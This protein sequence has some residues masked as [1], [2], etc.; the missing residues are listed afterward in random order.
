[1]KEKLDQYY[2][3]QSVA[4]DCVDFLI[5]KIGVDKLS[6]TE[7]SA[8]TGVFLNALLKR[9]VTNIT[10]YDLDPKVKSVDFKK[11]SIGITESDWFEVEKCGDVVVGNPP[12]GKGGAMA[13][14]FMNHAVEIGAKYIA[15]INPICVG[16]K[17]FTLSRIHKN[18]HMLE[19]SIK[20]D[21]SVHFTLSD[22]TPF[23][24]TDKNPVRCEFQIWEVRE[25]ERVVEDKVFECDHFVDLQVSCD[26]VKDDQGRLREQKATVDADIVFY[27]HTNKKVRAVPYKDDTFKANICRFL[28]VKEG[29]SVE[30]VIE[31]LNGTDFSR[32]TD[33]ATISFNPSLSPSEIVTCYK[34]QNC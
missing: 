23:R 20:F 10:A 17:L 30:G 14:H 26:K 1:M 19:S 18:L 3:P 21:E 32:F 8:G 15:F 4:D 22:G 9:G 34:S 12:F 25:E 13:I 24:D 5:S 31:K 16:H 27:S 28:K 7:P 6:F 2:T 29:H 11:E 33:Y